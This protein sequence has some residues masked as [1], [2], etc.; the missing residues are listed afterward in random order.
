MKGSASA[1]RTIRNASDVPRDSEP[2]LSFGCGGSGELSCVVKH[3][4]DSSRALVLA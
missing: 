4:T 1:K 3:V 2:V